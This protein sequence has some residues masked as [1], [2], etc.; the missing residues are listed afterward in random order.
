MCVWFGLPPVRILTVYL[1]FYFKSRQSHFITKTRAAVPDLLG[2]LVVHL[3]GPELESRRELADGGQREEELLCRAQRDIWAGQLGLLD[4]L[5]LLLR[6]NHRQDFLGANTRRHMQD[7][8]DLR[9]TFYFV[10]S[11]AAHLYA[12]LVE[13]VLVKVQDG[14]L[15]GARRRQ[16]RQTDVDG[17]TPLGIQDDDL[18]AL[19]VHCC[20]LVRRNTKSVIAGSRAL[21]LSPLSLRLFF[22]V[23]SDSWVRMTGIITQAT[24]TAAAWTLWWRGRGNSSTVQLIWVFIWVELQ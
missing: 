16:H 14:R 3:E 5:L 18:L 24:L 12:L 19:A 15:D 11:R 6:G 8:K 7:Q 22:P 20:F 23:W 10:S 21:P 1:F 13:R 17:V 2:R 4:L 9:M